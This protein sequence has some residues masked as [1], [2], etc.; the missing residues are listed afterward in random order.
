MKVGINTDVESADALLLLG[1]DMPLDKTVKCAVAVLVIVAV[2]AR[3]L[4]LQLQ[5]LVYFQS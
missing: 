4:Q 3:I 2:V 5:Y 1:A